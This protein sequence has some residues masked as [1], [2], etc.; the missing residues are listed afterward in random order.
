MPAT[1][2][3]IDSVRD[4]PEQDDTDR[5]GDH[6]VNDESAGRPEPNGG[7]PSPSRQHERGEH[8]LVWQLAEEDDREHAGSDGEVH[9]GLSTGT[10]GALRP[11]HVD[12]TT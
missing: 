5:Y 12:N 8:R 2:A 6:D 10:K 11:G 4:Q 3:S 1:T 7:G 9:G